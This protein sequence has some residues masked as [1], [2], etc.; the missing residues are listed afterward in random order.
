[1]NTKMILNFEN[2]KEILII[3]ARN[4]KFQKLSRQNT[5]AIEMSYCWDQDIPYQIVGS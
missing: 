5:V 1:M 3:N 2:Y 4:E